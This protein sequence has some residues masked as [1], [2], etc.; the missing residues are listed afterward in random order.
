MEAIL[1]QIEERLEQISYQKYIHAEEVEGSH[2]RYYAELHGR[3]LEL[4]EVLKMLSS[5]WEAEF[6]GGGQLAKRE[7]MG[8]VEAYREIEEMIG[9]M[10]KDSAENGEKEPK[11]LDDLIW[12]EV[13]KWCNAQ[14]CEIPDQNRRALMDVIR[15]IAVGSGLGCLKH[16]VS[17][18]HEN[19][20]IEI[21]ERVISEYKKYHNVSGRSKRL[22]DFSEMVAKNVPVRGYIYA[23]S[24][25]SCVHESVWQTISLHYS[26]EGAEKAMQEHKQRALDEFNKM[27]A[28]GNEFGFK[29]GEHEDWHI[30]PVEVLP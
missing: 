22:K 27:Y 24:Y 25:I 17:Y 20:S 11:Q 15:L 3:W 28:E 8:K 30:E 19:Y 14:S 7:L 23:F 12:Q 13:H 2:T 9:Q 26:K 1:K 10:P 4:N 21:P 29:F 16:F 5:F 6:E 18:C